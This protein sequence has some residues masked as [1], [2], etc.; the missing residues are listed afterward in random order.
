M[1]I[2]SSTCESRVT[3]HTDQVLSVAGAHLVHD[4]FSSFLSPLLPLI[5]DKL[6]LSMTLAGSLSFYQ[7]L[8][9]VVN[10]FIGMLADRVDLRLFISLA[11]GVTAVAMSL[12]GV[13]PS[14][15]VAAVL[16]LVTGL[17]SAAL[18]VP[19]PVMVA[20][21][22]GDQVGKGMSVWMTGGEL[23][24]TLGPLIAV[25]A[26]SLL[27]LEGIW[28]IMLVG[29][30]AS[31]VIYSRIKDTPVRPPRG[32]AHIPLR[33]TWQD[34]QHL[35]IPLTG[36]IFSRSLMAAALNTFLP[37]FMTNQGQS[38]ESG[39]I[40][41]VLY[42][43]AGTVGALATGT[44]SD[45]IGRKWMLSVTLGIAPFLM[46]LFLLVE[47]WLVLPVLMLIGLISISTTPV[48]MA[49]VQEH[50][51]DQPATANG[52]YMGLS[53]VISA[54]APLLLGFLADAL[55]LNTAFAASAVVALIGVPLVHW[56]PQDTSA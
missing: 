53:F 51:N 10:P 9:S 2:K 38:F 43:L 52:L 23:A 21:V 31:F 49:M 50:A 48:M 22:S 54:T 25:S 47:G 56:L 11:P 35:F 14:Y 37:T 36:I 8:P 3:F 5:I 55:G 24:R 46:L 15:A 27:T 42:Q 18:H 13:A 16:L 28:P 34:M 26:V 44:L 12:L 7:R 33:Q 41:L 6:S 17:S 40:A 45:R 20:Q 32:R 4:V 1:A 19:G 39:G 30:A 29:I